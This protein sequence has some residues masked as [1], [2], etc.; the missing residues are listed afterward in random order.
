MIK[1]IGSLL[2]IKDREPSWDYRD[3]K[4][5][6]KVK[7][8]KIGQNLLNI[9]KSDYYRLFRY[10]W[11]QWIFCIIVLI[12]NIYLSYIIYYYRIRTPW[13][14][15]ANIIIYWITFFFLYISE[16]EKLTVDKKVRYMNQLLLIQKGVVKLAYYNIVLSKKEIVKR[17]E[18]II[19]IEIVN[20]GIIKIGLDTTK[21]YIRIS[22]DDKTNFLFG[23][24]VNFFSIQEKFRFLVA[25]IKEVIIP[26]NIITRDFIINE[27]IE[28]TNLKKKNK[29]E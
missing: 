22:F 21:Y 23:E 29:N 15:G 16:I 6:I 12:C 7:Y 20:K 27:I 19:D 28:Y 8:S 13:I 24:S 26:N 2:S 18:E 14:F 3:S 4:N 25:S 11:L 1:R 17:I 10:P 5:K 9:K